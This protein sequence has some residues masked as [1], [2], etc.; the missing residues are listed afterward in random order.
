MRDLRREG[1]ARLVWKTEFSELPQADRLCRHALTGEKPGRIC[2]NAFECRQCEGHAALC[3]EGKPL[4][5]M[6]ETFGL[7]Y[8]ADRLYHRGHAW[9]RPESDG[10]LTVGLD[11]LG[12]RLAGKPDQ[13][14]LPDIGTKLENNGPGWRILHRGVEFRIL[15]PVEGEVVATGGPAE[16]WYLKLQPNPE[17]PVRLEHLLSGG[18]VTAWLRRELEKIQVLAAPAGAAPALA[19]GG[20][21]M[22]DLV[23]QQPNA[24]WDRIGGAIF[25]EP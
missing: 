1:G 18:E 25:L 17:Q 3:R 4:P 12:R 23:A 24:D 19:D 16:G 21:L 15:A 8:P 2:P 7:D 20:V 10:T 13:V 22:E 5:P 9:V 6:T 11:D 14:M